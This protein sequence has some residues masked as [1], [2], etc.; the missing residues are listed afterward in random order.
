M[1]PC[2]KPLQI[3]RYSISY[4]RTL[5]DEYLMPFSYDMVVDIRKNLESENFI[6]SASH[7]IYDRYV[8]VTRLLLDKEHLIPIVELLNKREPL[9][10]DQSMSCLLSVHLG[11]RHLNYLHQSEVRLCLEGTWLELNFKIVAHNEVS[12]LS[13]L[14]FFKYAFCAIQIFNAFHDKVCEHCADVAEMMDTE[15]EVK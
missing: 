11:V 13:P 8:S 9:T 2:T 10:R 12:Q 14:E 7:S 3:L 1:L 15:F 4:A 6:P 5:N